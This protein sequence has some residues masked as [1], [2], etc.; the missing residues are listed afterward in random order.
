MGSRPGPARG[1]RCRATEGCSSPSATSTPSPVTRRGNTQRRRPGCAAPIRTRA[2]RC[3]RE[4]PASCESRRPGRSGPC[5]NSPRTPSPRRSSDRPSTGTGRRRSR[6]GARCR[7]AAGSGRR[8]ECRCRTRASAAATRRCNPSHRSARARRATVSGARR[9]RGAARCQPLGCCQPPPRGHE[10]ATSLRDRRSR[11]R[12]RAAPDPC[13]PDN[14]PSSRAAA[15]V[16]R[17]RPRR[18]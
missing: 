16:R 4:C 10:S 13:G 15:P 14:A 11:G 2:L 3:S 12:M 18:T 17:E 7:A 5:R 9:A 6:A 8:P 1:R